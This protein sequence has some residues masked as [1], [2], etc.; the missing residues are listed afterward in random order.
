MP[1]GQVRLKSF[2][3]T[4]DPEATLASM[5]EK[6]WIDI[7][8]QLDVLQKQLNKVSPATATPVVPKP[9][10]PPFRDIVIEMDPKKASQAVRYL[11]TQL[12]QKHSVHF[13]SHIHSSVV[14]SKIP[15]DF[16]PEN[17]DSNKQRLQNDFALTLIWKN[18]GGTDPVLKTQ[19]T[20]IYGMTNICR[21][22]CRLGLNDLYETCK[23]PHWVDM[24]LDFMHQLVHSDN[25]SEITKAMALCKRPLS[26]KNVTTLADICFPSL[27]FRMS[28]DLDIFV[29]VPN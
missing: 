12:A 10:P 16:W 6:R 14:N 5:T 11:A 15:L 25:P 19:S 3:N 26:L 24:Q 17:V 8:K 23:S 4:R 29:P 28:R 22:L 7:Q 27:N 13:S 1:I 18:V 2:W 21:Y 9:T 20:P